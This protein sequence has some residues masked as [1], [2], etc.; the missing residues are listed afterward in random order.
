LDIVLIDAINPF[1]YD[2]LLP[3]GLLREPPSSL[4]RADAIVV[5][6]ADLVNDRFRHEL[7]DRIRRFNDSAPLAETAARPQS[8]LG[9]DET[10]HPIDQLDGKTV[11]GFCGIGNPQGFRDT[12]AGLDVNVPDWKTFPDHHAYTRRDLDQIALHA[13]QCDAQAVVCTH[14]D[15][16]KIGCRAINGLPVFALLIETEF[17]TGQAEF[18]SQLKRMLDRTG[19][20]GRQ[21]KLT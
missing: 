16:V 8:W 7:R 4:A 20:A 19:T 9:A 12:L 14:K 5:T 1:G 21:T 17:L 13:S 15:L 6:R 11:F 10:E 18:E 2:R 3:R